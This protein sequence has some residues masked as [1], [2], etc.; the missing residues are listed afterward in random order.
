MRAPLAS[1]LIPRIAV[2]ALPPESRDGDLGHGVSGPIQPRRERATVVV[3]LGHGIGKLCRK[4]D[5]Q[6]IV[7]P[8][9]HDRHSAKRRGVELQ[10]EDTDRRREDLTRFRIV[11]RASR[12]RGRS[13]LG[14]L[15]QGLLHA[16][17]NLD[18][19]RARHN[20]AGRRR[21]LGNLHRRLGST[22]LSRRDGHTITR[23]GL[24][25]DEL[26]IRGRHR[27][28]LRAF[29]STLRALPALH[30]DAGRLEV[31]LLLH[32]ANGEDFRFALVAEI[33]FARPPRA[34]R[35]HVDATHTRNQPQGSA[36]LR[37]RHH[38]LRPGRHVHAERGKN[39][40]GCI[41]RHHWFGPVRGGKILRQV[42]RLCLC[43][44]LVLGSAHAFGAGLCSHFLIRAG[45]R[46]RRFAIV[47]LARAPRRE[48]A[49]CA[50]ETSRIVGIFRSGVVPLGLVAVVAGS[51]GQGRSKIT[52]GHLAPGV[53]PIACTCRAMGPGR[54]RGKQQ[55]HCS[56]SLS[57]WSIWAMRA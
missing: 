29:G 33:R 7:V 45:A 38:P 11:D 50:Q 30:L 19:D 46:H 21:R 18:A 2:R 55:A 42:G 36:E 12:R 31:S 40:A 4:L 54:G 53:M 44:R 52:I 22:R 3:D 6:P 23:R 48:T 37:P 15:A 25:L 24:G 14:G 43:R 34:V 10:L 57:I 27:R 8:R 35:I 16:I 56:M 32:H 5:A 47:R 26:R 13:R 1:P 20:F 39:F 41:P 9:E 51:L 28:A 49:H 17:G